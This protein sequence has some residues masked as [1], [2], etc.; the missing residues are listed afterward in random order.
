MSAISATGLVFTHTSNSF[1]KKDDVMHFIEGL[2]RATEG[3]KIAVFWDNASI[4]KATLVREYL[5]TESI[6]VVYSPPYWPQAAHR[7]QARFDAVRQR[8][9]GAKRAL[10]LQRS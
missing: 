4:H 9:G 10:L 1:F 7:V 3:R 2:R 5:A 8:K 6:P